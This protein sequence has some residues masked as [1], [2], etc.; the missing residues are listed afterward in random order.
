M[1]ANLTPQVGDIDLGESSGVAFPTR[2]QDEIFV[3]PVRE[4]LTKL[5][6]SAPRVESGSL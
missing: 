5:A 3:V 2:T 4:R 6:K 1:K